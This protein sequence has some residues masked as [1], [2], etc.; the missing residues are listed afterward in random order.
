M[1]HETAWI[2]AANLYKKASLLLCRDSSGSVSPSFLHHIM[3]FGIE[4]RNIPH[5]G[6]Y[7][8]EF[9]RYQS[10]L[11]PFFLISAQAL[12]SLRFLRMSF[13]YEIENHKSPET[14]QAQNGWHWF[15]KGH[16]TD[17]LFFSKWFLTKSVRYY[18]YIINRGKHRVVING[19]KCR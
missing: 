18:M 4:R 16:L 13:W 15:G 10:H 11:C 9:V 14:E 7:R 5:D 6:I 2:Y 12:F 17:P 19:N 3:A 8:D 1:A